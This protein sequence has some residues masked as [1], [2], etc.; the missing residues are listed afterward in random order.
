MG[1]L[2][3][4]RA[5]ELEAHFNKRCEQV[6]DVNNADATVKSDIPLILDGML[7]RIIPGSGDVGGG[8]WR[9]LRRAKQWNGASQVWNYKRMVS[10]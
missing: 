10:P 2:P 1:G 8:K 9:R 7:P 4:I 5:F 3:S 6:V